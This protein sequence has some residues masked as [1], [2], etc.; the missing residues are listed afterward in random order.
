MAKMSKLRFVNKMMAEQDTQQVMGIPLIKVDIIGILKELRDEMGINGEKQ[1]KVL[2]QRKT[3]QKDIFD[4]PKLSDTLGVL[5]NGP[6]NIPTD[7]LD[8]KKQVNSKNSSKP[9]EEVPVKFKGKKEVEYYSDS[10]FSIKPEDNIKEYVI[11][12]LDKEHLSTLNLQLDYNVAKVIEKNGLVRID[13]RVQEIVDIAG[14]TQYNTDLLSIY[15]VLGVPFEDLQYLL[16]KSHSAIK[17]K[18]ERTGIRRDGLTGTS[19]KIRKH[20]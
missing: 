11:T 7:W 8:T 12:D 5:E 14:W 17:N 3:K 19:K 16:N 2:K 6:E 1:I 15:Y 10:Y 9:K 13:F 20:K 4:I 18:L